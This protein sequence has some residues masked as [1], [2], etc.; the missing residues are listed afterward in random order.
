MFAI[1]SNVPVPGKGGTAG[2]GRPRKYPFPD[3]RV[4]QS[5]VVPVGREDPD[6]VAA[7]V[8][9]SASM[10]GKRHRVSLTTRWVPGAAAIRV[11]RVA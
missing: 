2:R 5:F 8:R 10:Y 11:W 7:R 4:G 9:V 1:E 6:S 3:L